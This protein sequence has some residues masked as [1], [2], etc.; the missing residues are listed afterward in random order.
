MH[1]KNI[2]NLSKCVTVLFNTLSSYH[3]SDVI[4]TMYKNSGNIVV[5]KVYNDEII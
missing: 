4:P 2:I 5:Y 3:E 1:S